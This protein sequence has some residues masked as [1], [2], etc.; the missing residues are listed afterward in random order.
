MDALIDRGLSGSSITRIFGTVRSIANFAASEMDISM[1]NPFGGFY[2]DRQA[3]VKEREPLPSKV[4]RAVQGECLAEASKARLHHSQ[5][6][7]ADCRE[8]FA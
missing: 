8:R 3:E 7:D 2:F 6:S 1:T 4:V 5:G